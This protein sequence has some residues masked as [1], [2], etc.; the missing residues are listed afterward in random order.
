M[1]WELSF[2]AVLCI[3]HVFSIIMEYGLV[4]PTGSTAFCSTATCVPRIS[5]VDYTFNANT[6]HC[7]FLLY[8]LCLIHHV[9]QRAKTKKKNIY[10]ESPSLE[11]EVL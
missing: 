11:V 7:H 9:H 4:L 8:H 6:N 3:I 2:N 5:T 10:N 1:I